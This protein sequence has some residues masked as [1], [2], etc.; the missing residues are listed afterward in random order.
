MK[1]RIFF[2]IFVTS[3]CML[4]FAFAFVILRLHNQFVTEMQRD[5]SASASVLG[6]A[7]E[8]NPAL[9]AEL[10]A[11]SKK[12]LTLVA[13]D[14]T[15]L[16]DS[17][18]AS[19]DMENHKTRPEIHQGLETGRGY[20]TRLSNTLNRKAY[21]VA[22][23]L[24]NGNLLRLSVMPKSPA[25]AAA[26]TLPVIFL[27]LF[28]TV[29]VAWG[30]AALLTRSIMRPLNAIDLDDPLSSDVYDELS[31]LLVRIAS[32]NRRIAEQMAM[33]ADRQQQLTAI[34]DNMTEG[35]LVIGQNRRVLF[36]NPSTEA[37]FALHGIQGRHFLELDRKPDWQAAVEGA[38]DG[39]SRTARLHRH[40]KIWQLS[41]NPTRE[42]DQK[43]AA[44][45]FATDITEKE[46]AEAMRREFS[47]NVSHELKTPLTSII[48]YAEIMKQ[49][50]VK[51]EDIQNFAG[52]IHAEAH[53]LLEMVKNI[54]MLSRLDEQQLHEAFAPVDLLTLCR[55]VCSALADKASRRGV[56]LELS[57]KKSVISGMRHPLFEMLFNICDNAITYNKPEGS[58]SI[59]VQEGKHPAVIVADTGIGID[60]AHQ[61]RI[62]ERFYRVEKSRTR[63]A[64][65]ER[66]GGS[67]L[68][69]AIARHVAI[70]HKASISV[71]SHEGRG[72]VVRI[73]WEEEQ[74]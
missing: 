23:R 8:A 20:G 2:S 33:L 68:G 32:Q 26:L 72:T 54:L 18:A 9:L 47:A 48:G 70:L 55:E 14:G 28:C 42:A 57:G 59:H 37:L 1:K 52:R 40:G 71:E 44:L 53:R 17:K 61:E 62:F 15:V 29:A 69:L 12:R 22:V 36:A 38:L 11:I 60:K 67:G 58:V 50:L 4:L 45:V 63:T 41:A 39:K 51:S 25:D 65:E 46:S 16:F 21:Y 31:P 10:G 27:L 6:R 74:G 24:E 34:T 66:S 64:T 73:C 56:R 3:S 5:L 13:P 30:V 49:G 19:A 43:P 7:L 35:M